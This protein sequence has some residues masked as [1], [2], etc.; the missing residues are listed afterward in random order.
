MFGACSDV[1]GCH[2]RQLGRTQ[3]LT[4]TP[5]YGETCY[6]RATN[7]CPILGLP[8]LEGTHQF[9]AALGGAA[10]LLHACVEAAGCG[11]DTWLGL[12]NLLHTCVGGSHTKVRASAGAGA[13]W[14]VR[15]DGYIN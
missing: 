13:H 2:W 8:S 14:C 6:L 15:L 1:W 9:G 5:H 4:D 11:I 10:C 12:A 3:K 7:G